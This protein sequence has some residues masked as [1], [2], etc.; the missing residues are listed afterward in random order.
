VPN[1][2]R[3][4]TCKAQSRKAPSDA[5]VRH[6]HSTSSLNICWVR[7]LGSR[8]KSEYVFMSCNHPHQFSQEQAHSFRN[9][10]SNKGN[11]TPCRLWPHTAPQATGTGLGLGPVFSAAHQQSCCGAA[12]TAAT[13]SCRSWRTS[14]CRDHPLGPTGPSSSNRHYPWC[15]RF[16][17]ALNLNQSITPGLGGSGKKHNNMS[18]DW[19][20]SDFFY[21]LIIHSPR[22][23]DQGQTSLSSLHPAGTIKKSHDFSDFVFYSLQQTSSQGIARL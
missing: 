17:R 18:C 20:L 15:H 6:P 8:E 14:H 5:S 23:C 2:N 1:K 4:I 11:K 9:W 22:D 7:S 10:K 19:W 16:R 13:W 12:C 21:D 3:I